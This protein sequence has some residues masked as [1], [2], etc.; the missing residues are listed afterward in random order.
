M[1][2]RLDRKCMRFLGTDV[3]GIQTL[4]GYILVGRHLGKRDRDRHPIPFSLKYGTPM[5][6]EAVP[7]GFHITKH[8]L[9]KHGHTNH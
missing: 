1:A 9:D 5:A 6:I 4:M 7:R 3:K 2:R 8:D